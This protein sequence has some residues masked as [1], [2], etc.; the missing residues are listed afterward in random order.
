LRFFQIKLNFGVIVTNVALHTGLGF[1]DNENL[2]Y[3]ILNATKWH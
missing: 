1:K 3:F 2:L